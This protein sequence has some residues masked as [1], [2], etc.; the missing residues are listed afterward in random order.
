MWEPHRFRQRWI[1]ILA[2][3]AISATIL[4]AAIASVPSHPIPSSQASR[5]TT[6]QKHPPLLLGPR[7]LLAIIG[8]FTNGFLPSANVRSQSPVSLAATRDPRLGPTAH[9][10]Q[11]TG[12]E[13]CGNGIP[14]NR[15]FVAHADRGGSQSEASKGILPCNMYIHVGP[16]HRL[17]ALGER[18]GA[19]RIYQETVPETKCIRQCQLSY[20]SLIALRFAL[21]HA[22]SPAATGRRTRCVKPPP[23]YP[24]TLFGPLSR[25]SPSGPHLWSEVSADSSRTPAGSVRRQ[26]QRS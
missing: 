6:R 24:V 23:F 22:N 7:V 4:A 11:H 17:K 1:G 8:L 26:A 13:R 15:L 12:K 3:A 18:K 14:L 21:I 19:S 25:P 20:Q 2:N 5:E 10:I 9:C 16:R